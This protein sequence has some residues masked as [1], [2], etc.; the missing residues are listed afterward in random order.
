MKS[1]VLSIAISLFLSTPQAHASV[2]E[3]D[4]IATVRCLCAA[5]MIMKCG[6]VAGHIRDEAPLAYLRVVVK[7]KNGVTRTVT[8]NNPPNG[9][10]DYYAVM[11]NEWL[12][13]N[14]PGLKAGDQINVDTNGYGLDVDT[15][16]FSDSD[17]KSSI[18]TVGDA[19]TY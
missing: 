14:I 17:A 10:R 9:I 5:S 8:L 1:L 15:P 3:C 2:V 7:S 11:S 16:L 12:L 13:N 6:K 19:L 18:G 4:N